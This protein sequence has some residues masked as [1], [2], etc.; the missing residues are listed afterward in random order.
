MTEGHPPPTPKEA[1]KL[2]SEWLPNGVVWFSK[3]AHAEMKKDDL[4]VN[5][6]VNVIR[7]GRILEPPELEHGT[8]RYRVHT[9]TMA[10]CVAFGDKPQIRVVTAWRKRRSR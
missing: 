10:V 3:H 7:C 2:L 4:I 1:R 5:D 9:E 8:W 6:V